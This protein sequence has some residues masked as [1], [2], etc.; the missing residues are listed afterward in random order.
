MDARGKENFVVGLFTSV[1]AK[2]VPL[3]SR[4]SELQS[5]METHRGRIEKAR[6]KL[7]AHADRETIKAREVL[8]AATWPEWDQF[9][10]DLGTFVSLVHEHVLGSPFEIRAAMVRGDVEMVL[11]KLQLG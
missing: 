11:K 5:S 6:H 1:F 3:H 8:G 7:T 4:L 2:V 9:W 10:R